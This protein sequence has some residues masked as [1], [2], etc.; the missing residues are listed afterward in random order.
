[1]E[2]Y[3]RKVKHKAK[4]KVLA[5]FKP[6]A[7]LNS[8]VVTLQLFEKAAEGIPVPGLKGALGSLLLVIE[9]L[10][11]RNPSQHEIAVIDI[12]HQKAKQNHEDIVELNSYLR[13]LNGLLEPLHGVDPFDVPWALRDRI[14]RLAE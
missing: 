14:N 4:A 7:A 12:V 8:V 11:V 5:I 6:E 10:Q 1:M 3:A 2:G 9:K 13:R